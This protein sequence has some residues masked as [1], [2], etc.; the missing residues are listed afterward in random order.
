VL[1]ILMHNRG[2]TMR[3]HIAAL[4]MLLTMPL[5]PST[6]AATLEDFSQG[7]SSGWSFFTDQVMGGVSQGR[8]SLADGALRLEG[9]V[10]TANNGGFIQV[11]RPVSL[12]ETAT[13][14]RLRVRG[15]GQKYYLHLRTSGTRMPWQYYQIGFEA[16]DGWSDVTLPLSAFEASGRL[17]RR[18]PRAN[19]VR[20]LALVAYG[21]DHSAFVEVSDIY[22]E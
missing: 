12:P 4:V 9:R 13:Q 21:R 1:V 11:R 19:A 18:M 22:I 17:M 20:T 10:S 2:D 6:S 15:N 14:I 5:T 16:T 7:T 8:A 3:A